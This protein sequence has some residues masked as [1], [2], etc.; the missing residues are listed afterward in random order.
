MPSL[1]KL[2]RTVAE[3]MVGSEAMWTVLSLAQ[4]WMTDELP[5]VIGKAAESSS[6]VVVSS[7]ESKSPNK[8][9]HPARDSTAQKTTSILLGRRL[10]YS[11]HIISTKKRSVMRQLA[12]ELHLTGYVK[13][14][15]PGVIILEGL[16]DNCQT[17]YDTIRRWNWQYL[18][19]RGEM[20]ETIDESRERE[21]RCFDSF[22]EVEEMSVVANHCKEV[23]LEALF[24]TSMKVYENGDETTDTAMADNADNDLYG[25]LIYADHMNDGKNYRKWLRK[26]S[27]HLSLRLIIKECSSTSAFKNSN[28]NGYPKSPVTDGHPIMILVAVVGNKV[29]VS[30]FLK[31]WRTTRVDVDSKG[32]PCLERMMTVLR[33]EPLEPR[34]ALTRRLDWQKWNAEEHVQISSFHELEVI[35]ESIGGTSWVEALQAVWKRRI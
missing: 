22:C 15:W 7:S 1:V 16:E 14:G 11:H 3:S 33:E 13:I 20:Q 29:Q 2:C 8:L 17:F 32:K 23:G 25:A 4:E 5:G 18:V 12:S 31:K 28:E 27:D 34:K 9:N 6:S 21:H 10:I 26:T 30:S 24:R 35:F 19:V